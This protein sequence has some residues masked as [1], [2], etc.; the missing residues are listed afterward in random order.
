MTGNPQ[1]TRIGVIGATGHAGRLITE[2]AMRRGHAVTAIVRDPS[3]LTSAVP[4][5]QRDVLELGRQ[6]IAGLDVLVNAFGVPVERTRAHLPVTRHLIDVLTRT[7]T[8]L[9][10][11][12]SG[13]HLF[14][15]D[16][17]TRRYWQNMPEGPLRDASRVL[18]HAFETLRDSEHVRWTYLAPPI[19]FV[20]DGARTGRY[21]TGTDIVLTD[22]RGRSR[23][24]YA[25]YAIAAVDE[26]ETPGHEGEMFTVADA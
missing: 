8:R 1:Q 16:T 13:G 22:A 26:A 21:R 15:D 25:D 4:S 9:I 12:G 7:P 17:R 18:Q 11:V 3:R 14:T 19:D 2:E 23:I 20:K 10:V 5:V 6:D 24:G